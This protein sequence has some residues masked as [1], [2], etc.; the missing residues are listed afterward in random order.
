MSVPRGGRGCPV[1]GLAGNG[2]SWIIDTP[3]AVDGVQKF[4]RT[5]THQADP[6]ADIN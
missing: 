6:H 1:D 2:R 3:C 4:T 5:R